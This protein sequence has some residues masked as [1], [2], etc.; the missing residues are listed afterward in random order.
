[1]GM[2]G[3][4]IT[5]CHRRHH[6]RRY[7]Y[8]RTEWYHALLM[9]LLLFSLPIPMVHTFTFYLSLFVD[10][11]QQ[12]QGG[13]CNRLFDIVYLWPGAF[14]IKQYVYVMIQGTS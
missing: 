2:A 7:P 1:M 14:S 9:H 10:S 4:L 5:Y 3:W 11:C 12:S 13:M 6:H 8:Q